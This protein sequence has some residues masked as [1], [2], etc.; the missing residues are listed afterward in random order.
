MAFQLAQA[1]G[2]IQPT[3]LIIKKHPAMKRTLIVFNEKE[4]SLKRVSHLSAEQIAQGGILVAQAR[5]EMRLQNDL[6]E[7]IPE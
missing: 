7:P 6:N 4:I 1:N 5:H 2:P 3:K